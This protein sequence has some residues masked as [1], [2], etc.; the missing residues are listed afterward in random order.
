MARRTLQLP[1]MHRTFPVSILAERADGATDPREQIGQGR[2]YRVSISSEQTAP[3]W[4]WELGLVNETLSHKKSAV[5]L[6]RL[7]ETGAVL[8]NHDRYDQVG[9]LFDPEVVDARVVG[10]LQYSRTQRGQDFELDGIDGIRVSVSVGYRALEMK[11]TKRGDPEKGEIDEY[12]ITKWEPMEMSIVSIPADVSVGLGR[13]EAE[14]LARRSGGETFPA[15]IE[16]G[17]TVREES[18]MPK[19]QQELDREA[20]AAAAAVAVADPPIPA[21]KPAGAPAAVEVRSDARDAE[22]L[23]IAAMARQNG[24]DEK[25]REW[26]ERKLTPAQVAH[27]IVKAR[28]TSAVGQG[29]VERRSAIEDRDLRSYSLRRAILMTLPKSEGGID[30]GGIEAEVD[31]Y[32]DRHLPPGIKRQGGILIPTNMPGPDPVA[33]KRA[34]RELGRAYPLDSATST[35]GTE[36]KFTQ[37]GPFIDMLRAKLIT[38]RLGARFMPGLTGPTSFPRQTGG[39]TAAWQDGEATAISDSMAAFN[40]MTLTGWRF[41]CCGQ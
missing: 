33:A 31:D 35:E 4:Y 17:D 38:A 13:H 14:E 8:W 19:T 39:S 40:L 25:V 16:D 37:P 30:R 7:Q 1:V 34:A 27:E 41:P 24:M 12:L 6:E 3:Q 26:V 2:R 29:P 36:F 32:L 22:I 11:R 15:E 9:R 18:Q 5:L 28:A 23:E 21:G 10:D 20:A